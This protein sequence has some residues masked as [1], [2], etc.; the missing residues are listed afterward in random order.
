I[1]GAKVDNAHRARPDRHSISLL[2]WLENLLL[3]VIPR[4]GGDPYSSSSGARAVTSASMDSRLRGNDEKEDEGKD[5][6]KRR[7]VKC[8]YDLGLP[9]V[10]NEPVQILL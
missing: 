4:E 6:Q 7:L 9:P 10:G 2:M 3:S 1:F 5:L 8:R